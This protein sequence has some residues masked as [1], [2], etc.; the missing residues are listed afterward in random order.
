MLTPCWPSAGPTGGAGVACPPGHWSFTLAVI[1]FAI[2]VSHPRAGFLTCLTLTLLPRPGSLPAG[3]RAGEARDLPSRPVLGRPRGIGR[4][5]AGEDS[6]PLQLPV[7]EVDRRGTI[8]DDQH[9]LH[10]PAPLDDL[11]DGALEV[12]ERA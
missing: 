9:H 7:F 2:V 10:Q 5:A 3:G 4:D 12:L 6:D 1:T 8:E 11:L